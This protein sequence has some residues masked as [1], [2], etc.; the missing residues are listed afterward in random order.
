[1]QST[2]GVTNMIEVWTEDNGAGY[3]FIKMLMETV[4]GAK[5]IQVV[6]H[7]GNGRNVP[8]HSNDNGGVWYDLVRNRKNRNIIVCL[9]DLVADNRSVLMEIES[10]KSELHNNHDKWHIMS[11]LYSFEYGVLTYRYLHEFG[12][13]DNQDVYKD[14]E[15]YLAAIKGGRFVLKNALNKSRYF[16]RNIDSR[17]TGEQLGKSILSLATSK[18]NIKLSKKKIHGALI[19]GDKLGCCWTCNCCKYSTSAVWLGCNC[20]IINQYASIDRK[21]AR[22]INNSAFGAYIR[23]IDNIIL[24]RLESL[25]NG[26][27]QSR[28]EVDAQKYIGKHLENRRNQLYLLEFAERNGR[29]NFLLAKNLLFRR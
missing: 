23:L 15:V 10:I 25:Y 24:K 27:K 11:G 22:L 9:M 29:W 5:H 28:I 6:P 17:V 8:K 13:F 7:S 16:N 2:F 3:K 21:V 20:I 4:Y 12:G 26:D 14:I 18:A 1:M 19:S